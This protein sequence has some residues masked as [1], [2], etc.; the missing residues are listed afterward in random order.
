[1]TK[2]T[3]VARGGAAAFAAAVVAAAALVAGLA[4]V[5]RAWELRALGAAA[6]ALAVALLVALA[7]MRT[8]ARAAE[9]TVAELRDAATETSLRDALTGLLDAPALNEHLV[10]AA[11]HARRR[12]EP[13]S[14]LLVDVC[15]LAEMNER[16]GHDAGDEVLRA[17]A[18]C[19]RET[20]RG[21]DTYGRLGGDRFLVILAG[22]IGVQA[23]IVAERLRTRAAAVEFR[24]LGLQRGI[25]LSI[26][27]ATAVRGTPQMLLEA[28]SADLHRVKALRPG[29]EAAQASAS[30]TGAP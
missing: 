11:A 2:S 16:A 18:G 13:L 1:M 19:M 23:E 7:L 25:E 12:V 8:R 4:L 3:R 29:G 15:R 5:Q 22:T 10:R 6:L 27:C 21:E 20:L 9:A 30:L 17:L 14:V 28:A 26:G 24:R